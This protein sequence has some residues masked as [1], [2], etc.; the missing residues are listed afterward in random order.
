MFIYSTVFTVNLE[1]EFISGYLS[2]YV[3]G[4]LSNIWSFLQKQLTVVSPQPFLQR[5]LIIDVW[6]GPKYTSVSHMLFNIFLGLSPRNTPLLN[7]HL[8]HMFENWALKRGKDFLATRYHFELMT[9][10]SRLTFKSLITVNSLPRPKN[11]VK[12]G[13]IITS[14]AS[15]PLGQLRIKKHANENQNLQICFCLPENACSAGI[16]VKELTKEFPCSCD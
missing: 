8:R 6:L 4:T 7:F 2:R 12:K 15:F 16:S 10:R 14:F 13:L 1:H 11:D 5:N 9:W 3:F